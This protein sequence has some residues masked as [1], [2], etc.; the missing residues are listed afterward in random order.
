MLPCPSVEH[1]GSQTFANNAELSTRIIAPY[2]LKEEYIEILKKAPI[3][4]SI[5]TD[6]HIKLAEEKDIA[7]RMTYSRMMFA[8]KWECKDLWNTPQ[9]ETHKKY[10]DPF[11]KRLI[12]WIDNKGKRKMSMV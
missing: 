1:W 9:I 12:N 4:M 3:Q 2:L 10:I 5:P 7:Y 8:K 6:V 11:P